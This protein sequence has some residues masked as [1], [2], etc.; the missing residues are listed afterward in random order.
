VVTLVHLCILH[1]WDVHLIPSVG[2]SRAF[3]SH[4]EWAEIAFD[5]A[6]QLDETR[7]GLEQGRVQVAVRTT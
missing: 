3:V 4:D 6:S 2:Y 1:W 5:D 7:A